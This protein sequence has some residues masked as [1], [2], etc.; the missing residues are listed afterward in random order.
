M[1]ERKCKDWIKSFLDYASFSEAPMKFLF[2]TGV[3]TVAGALR[4]RA[5]LDMKTFQWVPNFYVILVAPPGVVSKSTT[6]NIGMNL[7]RQL[8]DIR[9]GPDVATWQALVTEFVKAQELVLEPST[10]EYLP[11]SCLTISVDEFGTFLNPHDQE[12]VNV[13]IALWDG[14]R[15][16]F[17]KITKM[18]GNDEIENPWINLIACTTPDWIAGNFPDYM[19]GGG[20]TSRC[21]FVYADAKRQFVA[22]PDEQ[23]SKD[24]LQQQQD[25]VHD[26]EIISQLVGEFTLSPDARTWGRRWYE[27]H[28][29]NKPPELDND[30]FGGYLARK[31]TH[32]HK[33]SM[34]LSASC[35]DD[36]VIDQSL[37]ESA[38]GFVSSI[39][40]DMPQI[41]G[42]IG[43]S[44]ITKAS[45]QIVNIVQKHRAVERQAVY[46]ALFRTLSY[47]DFEIAL[48]S[49][50]NAG[51]V[52]QT[53][54][55]S[56]IILRVPS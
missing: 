52:V 41:Y 15:G 3:S 29:N 2:W 7:L 26:L 4:R 46:A 19:I 56:Q 20:F 51:K 11:M 30:Q 18:S 48:I 44:E 5:W 17:S 13:L 27:H 35:R 54:Q 21:I 43:Q 53:Q 31:Q 22:Y 38:E 34:V 28:W 33:L 16:R 1:A 55:G 39:E 9:F 25:L 23:A 32:I 36:L 6:I 12:M 45:H 10:G 50:I 42:R 40:S 8:D 37:L 49:A 14:K 24:F 47:K